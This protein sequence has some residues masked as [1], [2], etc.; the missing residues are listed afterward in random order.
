MAEA[1]KDAT[2]RGFAGSLRFEASLEDCEVVGKIPED[3]DGAFH[4]VGA[5]WYQ[6][7]MFPDDGYVNADGIVSM[8]RFRKGKVNY[9]G[10]WVKTQ[11]FLKEREAGR[12]LYGYY[13]NPYTDDPSVRDPARPQTRTLSNTATLVHAGK[14]FTLKEDGLPHQIDPNTLERQQGHPVRAVLRFEFLSVL[15]TRRRLAVAAAE[16][17]LVHP[18]DHARPGFKERRVQR[19]NPLAHAG[20]RPR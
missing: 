9:R 6:P 12:V 4:R 18:Q 2:R 15:S 8:F 7:P 20:V 10:K 17:A 1:P 19:G 13:R 3:L 14:L 11:R 5:E 16:G